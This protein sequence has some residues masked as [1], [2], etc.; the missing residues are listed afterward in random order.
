MHLFKKVVVMFGFALFIA[1]PALSFIAPASTLAISPDS[2]CERSLLGV[3]KPWF[4]GLAGRDD[5]GKCQVVSPGQELDGTVLELE[6]FVW[7]IA[8]NIVDIA[9]TIVGIIAFFFILYGGFLYLTGGDK[10]DKVEG[11]RKTIF[12]AV[13]GLVISIGAVAIINFTFGILR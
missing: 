7:R 12:N 1:T 9:L 10:P 5:N 11:A 8:L 2:S 3:I 6:G 4:R 13:I